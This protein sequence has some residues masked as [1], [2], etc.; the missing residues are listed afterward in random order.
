M[1][2]PK[3]KKKR[4]INKDTAQLIRKELINIL[5][6]VISEVLAAYILRMLG[7]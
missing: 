3:K 7:F 2:K 5:L 1:A 4:R 6:A